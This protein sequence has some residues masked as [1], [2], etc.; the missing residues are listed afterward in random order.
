MPAR[1]DVSFGEHIVV[2]G[3]VDIALLGQRQVHPRGG[4]VDQLV[5][6]LHLAVEAALLRQ[7]ADPVPDPGGHGTT[8]EQ[9]IPAV[10][11]DDEQRPFDLAALSA[12]FAAQQEQIRSML[13]ESL[14]A[15]AAQQLLRKLDGRVVTEEDL[16]AIAN[17]QRLER[18]CHREK[19]NIA[20][21]RQDAAAALLAFLT[22]ET[23]EVAS[24]Q[25]ES[26]VN[27]SAIELKAFAAALGLAS[28]QLPEGWSMV[29][30]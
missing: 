12:S 9:D 28:T 25:K 10:G 11:Q 3:F 18:F 15:I 4:Q 5:Y 19:R 17:W 14:V 27:C 1:G 22:I 16:R 29:C 21:H 6:A 24:G 26:S 2:D 7:V 23:A 20:G 30:I 13:S 8:V